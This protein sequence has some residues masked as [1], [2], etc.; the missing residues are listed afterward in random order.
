MPQDRVAL[1]YDFLNLDSVTVGGW[2]R[3]YN[4]NQVL[5]LL[6]FKLMGHTGRDVKTL[7]RSDLIF[8]SV[9]LQGGKTGEYVK[10]LFGF[11]V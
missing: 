9:Y 10:E 6:I 8:S 1:F 5:N 4:K 11:A 3:R 2:R 7:L